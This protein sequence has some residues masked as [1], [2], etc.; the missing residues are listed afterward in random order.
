MNKK[1][2]IFLVS[3]FLI[4]SSFLQENNEAKISALNQSNKI[5][6]NELKNLYDAAWE[7][8][9]SNPDSALM[10]AEQ[11]IKL[12]KQLENYNI[13]FGL[14]LKGTISVQLGNP[15]I[16]L[17]CYYE[18]LKLNEQKED[19]L[20]IAKSYRDIATVFNYM[21]E[22]NKSKEFY[23]KAISFFK[24]KEENIE[25]ALTLNNYGIS[26]MKSGEYEK[27]IRVLNEALL[28]KKRALKDS[29]EEKEKERL[30]TGIALL[31]SNLGLI[32][33]NQNKTNKA[34]KNL[35]NATKIYS[36]YNN[37]NYLGSS[38]FYLAKIYLSKNQI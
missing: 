28:Y 30:E 2:I 6:T 16:A 8:L 19:S 18:V 20:G 23:E 14:Y 27:G 31:E 4:G 13:E 36:K 32:Y 15:K 10:L 3:I 34:L 37:E 33:M 21:G 11:H 7:L 22:A 17:D 24:V 26:L 35:I 12:S 29:R 9:Y 1:H 25:L 5:D 38:Y